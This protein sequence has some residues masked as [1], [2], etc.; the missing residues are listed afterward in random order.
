VSALY[1]ADHL[2]DLRLEAARRSLGRPL[3]VLELGAGAGLPSVLLAKTY[4]W[5]RVTVSDFPDAELV[6]TLE[7]NV[8]ANGVEERCRA[9][10][11]AWGADVS[12]LW[13]QTSSPEQEGVD[14]GF[15]IVLAADTV[16]NPD[17]HGIFV[18]TLSRTLRKTK[19]AR[20]VLVAGL[21]TGRWTLRA[22][23]ERTKM[24]GLEVRKL[25]ERSVQ[26]DLRREWAVERELED[27]AERRNWVVWI[28]VGRTQEHSN[29][30]SS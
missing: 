3:R 27:E 21:H 8:R 4:D 1:L 24:E 15:D 25:E 20:V 11:Y 28:E 17:L 7:E 10:G 5:A 26:G 23:L 14:E 29:G 16:W 2:A 6:R 22:F 12:I 13:P 18:E 19:E 30:T 9:V